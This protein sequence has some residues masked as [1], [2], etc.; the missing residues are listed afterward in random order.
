MTYEI[1]IQILGN[2][3]PQQI[4]NLTLWLEMELKKMNFESK[5]ILDEY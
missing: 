2:K 3:N 4:F 5:I 1:K